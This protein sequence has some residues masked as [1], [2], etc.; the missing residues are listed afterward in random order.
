MR[1]WENV[2][3]LHNRK[4]YTEALNP[5]LYITEF[6]EGAEHFTPPDE[7][8]ITL[9]SAAPLEVYTHPIAVSRGTCTME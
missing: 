1:Q 2:L 9:A 3:V 6:A 7:I 8:M 4:V 5:V